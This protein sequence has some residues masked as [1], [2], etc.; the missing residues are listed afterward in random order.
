MFGGGYCVSGGSCVCVFS[1]NCQLSSLLSV[2]DTTC[3]CSS[4]L[5]VSNCWLQRL[6]RMHEMRTFAID[7]AGVC[8]S[9]SVSVCHVASPCRNG[10]T[11]RGPAWGGDCWRAKKHCARRGGPTFPTDY[12]TSANFWA[13]VYI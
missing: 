7:D 10:L 5:F 11:D 8:Q 12:A 9:A 3:T 1:I 13:I 6:R 4:F 2:D